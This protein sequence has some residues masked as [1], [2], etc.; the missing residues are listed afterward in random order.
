MPNAPDSTVYT[1]DLN[2]MGLSGTIASY[3]IPHRSGCILVESGPGSTVK[4]LR[5]G[6][7]AYGL[8]P[9]DV[10]DV[11][12]THIHLDHAG[13][14][15][16]LARQGARIHVHEVGAPHLLN[17]DR[18]LAS[19][20]R[21]YGEMMDTLWGEVLPVPPDRLVVHEDNDQIE[22]EGL[23]FRALDTPGHAYHHFAYLY[24]DIC[25]TGD[26]GGVRMAGV[27]HLR[28]PMPP[29]EFHLEKWQA[30]LARLRRETFRRIA[31][32]H[33]GVYDD[34]DWHLQA[35]EKALDDVEDWMEAVMPGEP[36]LERLNEAFMEW[37]RGRS[38]SDGIDPDVMKLYEAA[39]P[40][41]M[42][43]HGIQRYWNRHRKADEPPTG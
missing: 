36:S 15:G 40:S 11:L 10:T 4:G 33:F 32:T 14:S 25:F 37:T 9:A 1:L 23:C 24:E 21:I 18:L 35:L 26:I 29:P 19:A 6:L 42:S 22:V 30:S 28:L 27:R 17:P 38:L 20:A 34:P 2:F 16:W 13:A 8:A 5:D 12:L 7:Q 39:N 3:L 43:P 31:P 41:W